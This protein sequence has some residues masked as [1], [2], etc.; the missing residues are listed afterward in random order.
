MMK[1]SIW[2]V[3][4][5]TFVAVGCSQ[6]P[7]QQETGN[8]FDE[9]FGGVTAT[10]EAP[11]FGDAALAAADADE[12]DPLDPQASALQS[13]LVN[14]PHT[15]RVFA[16]RVIWGQLRFDSTSTTQ[17]VWDGSVSVDGGRVGVMRTIRFEPTTDYLVPR[18]EAGSVGWK[19]VT[20]V[21]NDGLLLL[22]GI[23]KGK[24]DTALSV[25]DSLAEYTVAF[26][27]KPLAVS[28][29]LR[30]LLTLDTVIQVNDAGNAVLF[31]GFLMRPHDCPKGFLGGVWQHNSDTTGGEFKGRW[32]SR[33]GLLMGHVEGRY[34]INANGLRVF[35]GKYIDVDGRFEGYLRG[36]WGRCT[37]VRGGGYFSGVFYSPTK[38]PMGRLHGHWRAHEA[39]VGVFQGIWKT[40]C[41]HWDAAGARWDDWADEDFDPGSLDDVNITTGG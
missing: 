26:E 38:E 6:T 7:T 29:P 28:F 3:A 12:Q 4:V 17:T 33:N 15:H 25:T 31:N 23:P 11:A 39:G 32:I 20:T 8:V 1:K 22:I 27:T 21:H 41:P 10:D 16:L 37:V 14:A 19:S 2:V 30:D 24:L 18:E 13:D 5:L 34:G 9:E 35:F 40:R 36:I